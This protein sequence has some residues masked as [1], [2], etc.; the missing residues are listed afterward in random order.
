MQLKQNTKKAK[1]HKEKSKKEKATKVLNSRKTAEK[2]EYD[3]KIRFAIRKVTGKF[4]VIQNNYISDGY[5]IEENGTLIPEIDRN[6]PNWDH[7]KVRVFKNRKLSKEEIDLKVR[8][9]GRTVKI[10]EF[11]ARYP[12]ELSGGQQQRVAMDQKSYAWMNHFQT[13]MLN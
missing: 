4:E 9:V 2:F 7:K 1:K 11:M 3:E 5:H 10:S 6:D 12:S 13:L 8:E